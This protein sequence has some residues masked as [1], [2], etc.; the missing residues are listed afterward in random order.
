MRIVNGTLG[1]Q[2]PTRQTVS[3]LLCCFLAGVENQV[4]SDLSAMKW[5]P[6]DHGLG[7]CPNTSG[8]SFVQLR[9]RGERGQVVKTQEWII[10]EAGFAPTAAWPMSAVNGLDGTVRLV[11]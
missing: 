11:E 1:M 5:E 6:S 7:S 2:R 4:V 3:I 10:G 9:Q 8:L